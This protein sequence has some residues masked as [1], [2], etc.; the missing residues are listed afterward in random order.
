M[1]DL[2]LLSHAKDCLHFLFAFPGKDCLHFLVALLV[3]ARTLKRCKIEN[4]SGACLLKSQA[5]QPTF[6]RSSESKK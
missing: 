5:Y 3:N 4:F 1:M 2:L 6:S